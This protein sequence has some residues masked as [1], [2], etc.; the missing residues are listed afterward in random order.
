[1]FGGPDE[2]DHLY[3]FNTKYVRLRDRLLLLPLP[4]VC[5]LFLLYLIIYIDWPCFFTV[6]IRDR[7]HTLMETLTELP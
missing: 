1:M 6:L 3:D 2:E 5:V 7:A 4:L